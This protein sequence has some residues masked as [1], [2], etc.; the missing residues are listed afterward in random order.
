M[1]GK[2]R[3]VTVAEPVPPQSADE[4]W[5]NYFDMSWKGHREKYFWLYNKFRHWI[6]TRV[7][8]LTEE[9]KKATGRSTWR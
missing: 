4:I 6:G 1:K 3:V 2:T 8:D 9:E 5:E 7:H